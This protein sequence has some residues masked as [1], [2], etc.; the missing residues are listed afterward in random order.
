MNKLFFNGIVFLMM[1]GNLWGLPPS[2]RSSELKTASPAT[3]TADKQPSSGRCGRRSLKMSTS[4]VGEL[5]KLL[6]PC[7]SCPGDLTW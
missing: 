5:L 3:E 6:G 1:L 2:A 7:N 4:N